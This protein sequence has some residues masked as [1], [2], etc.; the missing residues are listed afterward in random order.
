MY[1]LL[2]ILKG[3][4]LLL[5][6]LGLVVVLLVVGLPVETLLQ[7]HLINVYLLSFVR[8]RVISLAFLSYRICTFLRFL[9]LLFFFFLGCSDTSFYLDY[10]SSAIYCAPCCY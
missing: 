10:Y 1:D 5:A 6:A 9:G 8:L 7:F 4:D 3:E 2:G